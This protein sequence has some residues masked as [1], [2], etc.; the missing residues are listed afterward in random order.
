M[1]DLAMFEV[2]KEAR[3]E[4]SDGERDIKTRIILDQECKIVWAG[5]EKRKR[6]A[7]DIPDERHA[8]WLFANAKRFFLGPSELDKVARSKRKELGEKVAKLATDLQAT[9][10][11]MC[12]ADQV[13][14]VIEESLAAPF[15][16]LSGLRGSIHHPNTAEWIV[17]KTKPERA[18]AVALRDASRE[19]F[20]A[21]DAVNVLA[22]L[23]RGA[24]AWALTKPMQYRATDP[25][26]IYFV[27]AMGGYFKQHYGR[28]LI[29]QVAVLTNCLYKTA[30]TKS[31]VSKALKG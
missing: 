29:E 23:T 26:H 13:P 22:S 31:E 20:F 5:I 3:P 15:Q 6:D 14:L 30:T 1:K 18:L 4:L 24:Q 17:G 8:L 2:S 12:K 9:L 25:A 27:K 10:S 21:G 19:A 7:K 28:P 11:Q 16:Y